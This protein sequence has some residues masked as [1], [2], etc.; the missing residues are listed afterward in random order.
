MNLYRALVVGLNVW[1]VTCRD[2]KL[3]ANPGSFNAYGGPLALLIVQVLYL[4]PLLLWLD[5]RNTFSMPWGKKKL[6]DSEESVSGAPQDIEMKSMRVAS[7]E[8]NLLSVEHVSKSFKGKRAVDDVSL[9]MTEGSVIALLGP[10]GAGK[11]TLTNMMRGEMVPDSGRIFVQ[12]LDVQQDTQAARRHIGGTSGV[13]G[14]GYGAFANESK[15]V[16][17][18]MLWTKSRPGNNWS[19]TPASRASKT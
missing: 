14:K 3:I 4:F 17:S 5:G 10:N 2:F 13:S 1:L 8:K 11:T 18:S 12:G 7:S 15:S 9:A 16:H 6:V 19:S